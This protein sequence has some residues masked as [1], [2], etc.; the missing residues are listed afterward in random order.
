MDVDEWIE[1]LKKGK[2]I[3]ERLLRKYCEQ[4]KEILLLEPNVVPIQT[5]VTVCGDIHGQFYDFLH[6]F[7]IAGSLADRNYVFIGDFVD[8]GYNSVETFEMLLLLKI[9]YGSRIA[10]LRGNHESRQITIV[11]GFLDEIIKKY[12]NSNP[13]N[14]FLEV[15]DLLPLGGIINGQVF[16]IHG[17][18]SPETRTVDQI[19]TIDR[20]MEIPSSGPFCDLMWSDPEN[21]SDGWEISN[22]GAGWLFGAKPV[23][24]FNHVNGFK[25]ILRAHQLV[26]EGYQEWFNHRLYTVWS[27][28]NYCY[29]CGNQA[30]V[31]QIGDD[32]NLDFK[33]FLESPDNKTK[34]VPIKQVLPY[35]L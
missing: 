11:Y 24:E 7:E 1:N 29:R 12:G 35:F 19:R 26:Q 28:P 27:A 2:I 6:I 14:Y 21:I 20:N 9:K 34:N 30:S 3:P 25:V 10:L 23:E 5:P 32:M 13:W 4:V 31:V 16:G 8:R 17:G 33:V 22:R 15:F 18:I